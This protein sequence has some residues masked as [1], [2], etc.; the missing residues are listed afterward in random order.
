MTM[1]VALLSPLAVLAIGCG[2]KAEPTQTPPPPEPV[3]APVAAADAAPAPAADAAAPAANADAAAAPT[4]AAPAANAD[5]AAPAADDAAPAGDAAAPAGDAAPAAADAAAPAAGPT[6]TWKVEGFMTPESVLVAADAYYVANINGA[7]LDKD[8]NGFISKLGKDGKVLE[9]KWISGESADIELNAPKGMGVHEGTLFVADIDVVRRFEVATGKALAPI[10]IEGATFLNDV[11]VAGDTVYVSD[12]GIGADFKPK[13]TPAIY[14]IGAKD[15]EPKA[16]KLEIAEVGLP[17]GVFAVAKEGGDSV[18][19]NGFD[20]AKAIHG[21]DRKTGQALPKL[22][23]PAGSLDG[24]F[25]LAGEGDAWSFFV[26]SWE[27]GTVY[28]VA[29]PGQFKTIA[30]GLKGPADFGV[31]TDNKLV[32]VPVFMENRVDAYPY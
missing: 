24:L 15:A 26:S 17:N 29:A 6:A 22:D 16:V 9:L 1:R 14:A 19:F 11:H 18:Y 8:D 20:M 10:A 13:G 4:D 31:D 23:L 2:K 28:H 27:T 7:P 30:S 3:T 25:A 21:F 5:A 32:I 12:S